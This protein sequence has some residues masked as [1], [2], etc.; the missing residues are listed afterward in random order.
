MAE[1]DTATKKRARKLADRLLLVGIAIALVAPFAILYALNGETPAVCQS[2]ADLA[3]MADEEE[4]L[5]TRGL[6]DADLIE[7]DRFTQLKELQLHYSDIT[8]AGMPHLSKHT[9]MERL[10]LSAE[11]ISDRGIVEIAPMVELHELML[12]GCTRVTPAGLG[13][14]PRLPKLK[15][16]VLHRLAGIND[17][18][19]PILAKCTTLERLELQSLRSISDAIIADVARLMNLRALAIDL[20]PEITQAVVPLIAGMTNLESLSL[21]GLDTLT[22]EML[23]ELAKLKN[24]KKLNLPEHA[25]LTKEGVAKLKQLLPGCEFNV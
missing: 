6:T 7:L 21:I 24:L 17:E 14:V 25:K 4:L 12:L 13:F 3:L 11:T 23:L 16:L 19:G 8:D 5:V 1:K 20:C 2:G 10:I 22:D 15:V 18:F 9:G